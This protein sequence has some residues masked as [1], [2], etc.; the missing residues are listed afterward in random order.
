MRNTWEEVYRDASNAELATIIEELRVQYDLASRPEARTA[1]LRKAEALASILD[2]R[3]G[4]PEGSGYADYL[5]D[6]YEER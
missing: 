1:I 3:E 5:I 2:N 4:E 6:Q